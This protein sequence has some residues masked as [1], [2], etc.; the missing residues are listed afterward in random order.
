[1]CV[2]LRVSKREVPISQQ[3][4]DL[5]EGQ[6]NNAFP[7]LPH[8]SF[9]VSGNRYQV[10]RPYRGSRDEQTKESSERRD[11]WLMKLFQRCSGAEYKEDQETISY[12]DTG[13][14]VWMM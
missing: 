2:S 3:T 4:K 5:I 11:R 12:E 6:I 8:A 1:L 9:G 10:G 14:E 7:C 13:S